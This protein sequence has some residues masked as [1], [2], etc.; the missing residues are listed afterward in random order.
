LNILIV[1]QYFWPDNFRIND[2]TFY[3]QTQGHDVTVLTGLPNYPEG[4]FTPG[5]GLGTEMHQGVEIK[6]VPLFPRL[7]GKGWQLA[8]NYLSFALSASLLGPFLCRKKYDVIFVHEPSPITVGFPAIVMK[9]LHHIPIVFW[10]L[11]LWPESLVAAG[12]VKS[13]S[14]LRAGAS[15]AIHPHHHPWRSWFASGH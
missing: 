9:K 11:D 3:L 7:D 1:S 12:G 14:L 15:G 5:H 2:L 10:V 6:R 4:R 8:C 13:K